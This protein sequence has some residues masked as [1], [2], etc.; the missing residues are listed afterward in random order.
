MDSTAAQLAGQRVKNLRLKRAWSQMTLATKSELN[1]TQISAIERRGTINTDHLLKLATAFEVPLK[2]LIPPEEAQMDIDPLRAK[3]VATKGTTQNLDKE[4]RKSIDW[5]G[6]Q[7]GVK[8][9]ILGQTTLC[10]HA[11]TVGTIRFIKEIVG[12]LEVRGYFSVGFRPVY[13][14][15]SPGYQASLQRAIQDHFYPRLKWSPKVPTKAPEEMQVVWPEPAAPPAP[16]TWAIPGLGEELARQ[17]AA[18]MAAAQTDSVEGV[19]PSAAGVMPTP[20]GPEPEAPAPLE[21][22]HRRT[23]RPPQEKRVA[24]RAKHVEPPDEPEKKRKW[25]PRPAEE[26]RFITSAQAAKQLGCST[27]HIYTL[28]RRGDIKGV[29]Y[30]GRGPHAQMI[31][32]MTAIEGITVG[33]RGGAHEAKTVAVTNGITE[34]TAQKLSKSINRLNDMLTLWV[35]QQTKPTKTAGGAAKD[36]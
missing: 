30:L 3:H 35:D 26:T 14:Y 36:T 21:I 33:N 23:R 10:K 8:K 22:R 1:Q 11:F 13:I 34:A 7:R 17:A 9:V 15:H 32:P 5:L 27:S 4:L 6:V 31:M 24:K 25:A 16:P 2:E 12:G 20:P 28:V 18:E 19:S 29:Q